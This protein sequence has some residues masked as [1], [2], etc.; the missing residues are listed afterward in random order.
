MTDY[1]ENEREL[2]ES[3]GDLPY[4]VWMIV[5]FDHSEVFSS[6]DYDEAEEFWN[7]TY[8]A[9]E[10]HFGWIWNTDICADFMKWFNVVETYEG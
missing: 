3:T 4:K 5:D 7:N 2:V 10:G 1:L 8:A 6:A 9:G